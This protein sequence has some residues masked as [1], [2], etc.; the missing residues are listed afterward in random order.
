MLSIAALVEL[1]SSWLTNLAWLS[2]LVVSSLLSCIIFSILLPLLR[3]IA[4]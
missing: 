2:R 4:Y 1:Y 3:L